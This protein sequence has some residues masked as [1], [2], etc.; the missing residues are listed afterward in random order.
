MQ[1]FVVVEKRIHTVVCFREAA[2]CA[3]MAFHCW[4]ILS[5]ILFIPIVGYLANRSK[6]DHIMIY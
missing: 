6:I 2:T 4:A 5:I 3:S 1:F